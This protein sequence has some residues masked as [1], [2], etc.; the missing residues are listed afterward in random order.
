[1]NAQPREISQDATA[2]T[3][4]VRQAADDLILALLSRHR[5][6]FDVLARLVRFVVKEAT[7]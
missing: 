6:E 5:P 2:W 4:Q 3:S 1:M 7:A